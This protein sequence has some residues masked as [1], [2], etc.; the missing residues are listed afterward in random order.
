VESE[1]SHSVDRLIVAS[2]SRRWQV[3]RERG[4]VRS[5]EQFN[6]GGQQPYLWNSGSFQ[7]LSTYSSPVSVINVWWSSDSSWSHPP[8]R[9]LFS[10]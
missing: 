1:T 9:S 7:A 4:V 6:F 5:R 8:S 3:I 10:S 2:A